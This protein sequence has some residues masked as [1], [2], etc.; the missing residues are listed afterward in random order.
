VSV[1]KAKLEL[2][3]SRVKGGELH[4]I[5]AKLEDGLSWIG[6]SCGGLPMVDREVAGE[7]LEPR[8]RSEARSEVRVQ[9]RAKWREGKLL[10]VLDKQRSVG[11]ARTG[12]SH[13]GGGVAAGQSSGRGGATWSTRK[14]AR[15]EKL[16]RPEERSYGGRSGG[17]VWEL[18]EQE[19][20]PIGRQQR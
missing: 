14:K 1:G 17:G 15:G 9:E 7:E 5:M 19:V 10:S 20:A 3:S 18:P 2:K 12:A 13:D 6:R 8:R 11:E 4:G 16:G